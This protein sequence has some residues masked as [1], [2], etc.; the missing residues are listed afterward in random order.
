MTL[1]CLSNFR[2]SLEI[3]LI[4]CK[5]EL[6]LKWTRYCV[7]SAAGNENAI[8]DDNASIRDTKL[9]VHVVTLS[10]RDNQK[11]SKLLSKR[12]KRPVYWNEYKT[13]SEIKNTTIEFRYF[14]ES[15]FVG[16]NRLFVSV[17]WNEAPGSKRFKAKRWKKRFMTKQLVLI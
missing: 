7:L 6:K 15:N 17:Y 16:V 14:L 5:V 8:N 11:L 9:Y 3:P 4:N 2:R 10:A 1:K 12:F 13:K